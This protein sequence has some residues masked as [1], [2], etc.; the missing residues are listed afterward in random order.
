MYNTYK[1]LTY[2]KTMVITK[3]IGGTPQQNNSE[4]QQN[5]KI[6]NTLEF[7]QLQAMAQGAQVGGY[8]IP[9][10][11]VPGRKIPTQKLDQNIDY[12]AFSR[13]IFNPNADQVIDPRGD[14]IKP[15]KSNK[16]I[17]NVDTQKRDRYDLHNSVMRNPS[18]K[19]GGRSSRVGNESQ[20]GAG[21][22]GAG[23]RNLINF[24]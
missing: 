9:E 1:L 11:L 2:F 22:L 8:E 18:K 16:K 6:D 19:D 12:L 15:R 7:Q 5:E 17:Y 10:V 21:V 3:G 14:A 13:Q 24:H 4:N 23:L 20:V